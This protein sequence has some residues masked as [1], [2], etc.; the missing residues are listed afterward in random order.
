MASS[1]RAPIGPRNPSGNSLYQAAQCGDVRRVEALL[2]SGE[3]VNERFKGGHTAL[4]AALAE[5]GPV[6]E[7]VA[8]LLIERG[9][10]VQVWGYESDTPLH[11]AAWRGHTCAVA[12]LL[13]R[14]ADPDA[15]DMDGVTPLHLATGAGNAETAMLLA[16]RSARINAVS[17]DGRSALY[18]AVEQGHRE[19]IS[20]LRMLGA[21]VNARG[22]IEYIRHKDV[23]WETSGLHVAVYRDQHEVAAYYICKGADIN[24]RTAEGL[25]P[26]H[27]AAIVQHPA[28]LCL[29]IDNGADVNETDNDGNTPLHALSLNPACRIRRGH[30]VAEAICEQGAKSGLRDASGRTALELAGAIDDDQRESRLIAVLKAYARSGGR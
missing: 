29:L 6:H 11:Y 24:S 2:D 19:I 26:L 28:M 13:A 18:R 3:D 15:A 5:E 8:R 16:G 30:G 4:F 7:A 12:E 22:C 21:D 27:L 20:A 10:D 25:T 1:E 23:W 14:D 9:A 17:N